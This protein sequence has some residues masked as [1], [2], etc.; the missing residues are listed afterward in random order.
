MRSQ[1]ALLTAGMELLNSNKAATF[2]EI[3]RHAGVGRATL[4]RL[5]NSREKLIKAIAL[6]CHARFDE[7]TESIDRDATSAKDA[8]RLLFKL[9]MP[10]TQEFQFLAQLEYWATEDAELRAIDKQ[11]EA[12]LLALVDMAKKE[13]SI[14]KSLPSSWVVRMIECLLYAGWQHQAA[15]QS[16]VTE[17]AEFAYRSMFAGAGPKR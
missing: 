6:Y 4:Y 11:Q 8:I 10:L 12:E 17:A 7:A 2:S 16:T 5:F 13:G 1:E 14:C 9:A 15:K 3:A